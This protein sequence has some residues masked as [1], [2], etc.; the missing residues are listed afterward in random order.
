MTNTL[1]AVKRPMSSSAEPYLKPDE[2]SQ[3]FLG[4]DVRTCVKKSSKHKD[5][6]VWAD[7]IA[8]AK[9]GN[10]F[11]GWD[12]SWQQWPTPQYPSYRVLSPGE[13]V[14]GSLLIPVQKGTR[15]SKIMLAPGGGPTVAEW[16]L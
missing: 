6:V 3:E 9:N 7:W 1:L 10:V 8:G 2:P 11:S 4:A 16:N 13:C 12:S 5:S 14:S 15:I